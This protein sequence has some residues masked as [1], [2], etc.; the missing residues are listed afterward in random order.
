MSTY[1]EKID[2]SE[3]PLETLWRW[4][5]RIG[6]SQ[7][8]SA[9]AVFGA[10]MDLMIVWRATY[11]DQLQ[12][13]GAWF[14]M[15]PFVRENKIGTKNLI[16]VYGSPDINIAVLSEAKVASRGADWLIYDEGGWCFTEHK[17]Y[18]YYEASRAMIM[19]S[20]D[21]R[22]THASTPA[23]MT[24]FHNAFMFLEKQEHK[25]DTT[26]TSHHPWSDSTWITKK[27]IDRERELHSDCPWYIQQNYDALWI[28]YGGAVFT[29]VIEE[30]DPNSYPSFKN[31]FLEEM[32]LKR[33]ITNWGVDFNGEST[34]HYRVGIVYDDY[35]V[36]V[37]EET[38]FLD[39]LELDDLIGSVEVEDG[40]FNNVFTDQLR[41]MG[42]P[43]RYAAWGGKQGKYD[44]AKQANY[45]TRKQ[46]RVQELQNRKGIVINKRTCPMTWKNLLEA[47]NDK[48]SRLPKLAKRPD[49]HGLDALLHAMHKSSGKIYVPSRY[50]KERRNPL[51]G[52][53][54][55]YNP[56]EHM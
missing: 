30:G 14:D 25:L 16:G 27:A 35:Y 28:I 15:N 32:K 24:S 3:E 10:L 6:K 56:L 18:E 34:Q 42:I 7:K 12:Q 37:L 2:T 49:Q 31:G 50:K 19:D 5:R 22:I 47:G 17:K 40:L 45:D 26:L 54:R 13:A 41:R 38:K 39:L 23:K 46:A 48:N 36:Y 43:V 29:N 4:S 8:L 53:R 9:L 33:G 51:L 21:K 20:Q 1:N 44:S 52:G 11:T 55:I